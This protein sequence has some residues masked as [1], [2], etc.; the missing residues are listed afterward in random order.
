MQKSSTSLSASLIGLSTLCQVG[1]RVRESTACMYV[2]Y[3]SHS[4]GIEWCHSILEYYAHS[5]TTLR[6]VLL[7]PTVHCTT[8]SKKDNGL[9]EI[10]LILSET[11]IIGELNNAAAMKL[12]LESW[13]PGSGAFRELVSCSNCT[14]YQSRQLGTHRQTHTVLLLLLHMRAEG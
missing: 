6:E 14:D 5:M 10:I 13:F 4:M 3:C 7:M 12:D 8:V 9:M 11:C 2:M 1:R